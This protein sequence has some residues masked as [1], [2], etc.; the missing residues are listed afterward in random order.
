VTLFPGFLPR[1]SLR[2]AYQL[3]Q[4]ASATAQIDIVPGGEPFPFRQ[5]TIWIHC[6]ENQFP[7]DMLLARQDKG[8]WF[9]VGINQQ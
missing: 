2:T 1:L 6:V 7:L 5:E 4:T 3:K 8:D 9:V